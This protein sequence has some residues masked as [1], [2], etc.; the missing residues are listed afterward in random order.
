MWRKRA[1]GESS[2]TSNSRL[3]EHCFGLAPLLG[4]GKIGQ[5]AGGIVRAAVR[6]GRLL[7]LHYRR[8]AIGRR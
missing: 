4:G 3:V 8:F 7:G 2:P 1:M 5:R 6:D